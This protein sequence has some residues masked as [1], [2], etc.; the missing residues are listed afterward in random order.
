VEEEGEEEEDDDDSE[1]REDTVE[2]DEA[3]P[4]SFVDLSCFLVLPS[5]SLTK[6]PVSFLLVAAVAK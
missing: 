1:R 6:L 3:L 2:A 5:S 4:S